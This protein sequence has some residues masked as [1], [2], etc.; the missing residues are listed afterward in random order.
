MVPPGRGRVTRWTAVLAA[1]AVAYGL[2]AFTGTHGRPSRIETAAHQDG[3]VLDEASR[4]ISAAADKPVAADR[5]RAAAISGMLKELGD[6]WA[7]YY[8]APDYRD[9]N[10]WLNGERK[11]VDA[12]PEAGDVTVRREKKMTVVRVA[13]FTRGVGAQVRAA[14]RDSH[15]V[16][17]DLRGNPG[18]LLDEAV[19]TA[20]AFLTS[21]PVVT[22]EKRGRPAE[23]IQVTSPGDPQVPVVVLVDG[24]TASAAEIVAGC[25]RDRDRAVI[26][27]SST[28]GKGTVQEPVKLSDGS[29]VEL[30]VGRYLTPAGRNLEGVGIEPDVAVRSDHAEQ[31]ARDVLNV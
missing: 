10:A 11:T 4:R 6:P 23:V 30:T 21:G 19:D 25:L 1:L 13:V 18:G 16:I 31:R 20:S 3:S 27:G 14:V 22:Y 9:F 7:R 8:P 29:A 5:L 12:E 26:I 17:L 28:F 15:A 2:G 24:G